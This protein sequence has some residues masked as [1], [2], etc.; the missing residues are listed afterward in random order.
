M[1]K[2]K[3][4][5]TAEGLTTVVSTKYARV[6]Y[7]IPRRALVEKELADIIIV[8]EASAIMFLSSEK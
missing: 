1:R 7:V 3:S 8:D 5:E 6:E 4:K 2:F